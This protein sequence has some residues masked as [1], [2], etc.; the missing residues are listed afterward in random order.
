MAFNIFKKKEEVKK[1]PIKKQEETKAVVVKTASA[2]AKKEKRKISSF[3]LSLPHITEKAGM[4]QAQN[5][6]VFRVVPG[7]TKYGVRDSVEAQYGV[8][9][10][11]V[12][13]ITVSSKSIRVGKR[14]GKRP[15]YKKA[16][17]TLAEGHKIEIGA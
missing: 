3:A 17:I 11:K 7:S 10:E 14:M 4:L 2:P 8:E 16:V 1:T 5:Q 12:R 6:Y 15:G 13:M 9:V